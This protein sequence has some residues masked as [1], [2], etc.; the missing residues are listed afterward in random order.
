MPEAGSK[1]PPGSPSAYQ[2]HQTQDRQKLIEEASKGR[3]KLK[4]AAKR[5]GINQQTAKSIMRKHRLTGTIYDPFSSQ[6]EE[7][8]PPSI[9]SIVKIEE[10]T[11]REPKRGSFLDTGRVTNPMIPIGPVEVPQGRPGWGYA[12]C[13]VPV[14]YPPEESSS[15]QLRG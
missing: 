4:R 15:T 14:Y 13:L 6:E 10:T 2:L 9:P 8:R 5:L 1:A 12:W 3:G 11:P 7:V